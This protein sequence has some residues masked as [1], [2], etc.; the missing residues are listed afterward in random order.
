[1]ERVCFIKKYESEN[2]S[3]SAGII[4]YPTNLK[5]IYNIFT[6]NKMDYYKL[7]PKLLKF[8]KYIR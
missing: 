1:M 4:N 6:Q 8:N 2:I 7:D 3:I 5:T